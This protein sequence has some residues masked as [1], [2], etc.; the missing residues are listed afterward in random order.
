MLLKMFSLIMMDQPVP[1]VSLGVRVRIY[2]G[3]GEED[4]DYGLKIFLGMS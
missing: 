3:L 2:M 4:W 1:I